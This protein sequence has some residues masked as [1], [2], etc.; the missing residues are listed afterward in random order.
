MTYFYFYIL[1]EDLPR[2][3]REGWRYVGP[4]RPLGGWESVIVRRRA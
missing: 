3:R 2:Y 4:M 1:A